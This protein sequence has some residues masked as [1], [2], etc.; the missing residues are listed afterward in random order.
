MQPA[1]SNRLH[2]SGAI[3]FNVEIDQRQLAIHKNRNPDN[4]LK[5]WHDADDDDMLSVCEGEPLYSCKKRRIDN[6]RTVNSMRRPSQ[7]ASSINGLAIKNED[8]DKASDHLSDNKHDHVNALR[9]LFFDC[10]QYNGISVSKWDF[11]RAGAQQAQFV[12]TLGGGNT[13]YCDEECHA[14]DT[15]CVDIPIDIEA[16]LKQK[17]PKIEELKP[18]EGGLVHCAAKK[19]TSKQKRTMTVRPLPSLPSGDDE[20]SQN[21]RHTR[22]R[23]IARGQ[24]IGTCMT[25]A[26]KGERVDISLSQNGIIG[27]QTSPLD[28]GQELMLAVF[29]DTPDKYKELKDIMD[30]YTAN[31]GN[32]RADNP[33]T[34]AYLHANMSKVQAYLDSIK[35]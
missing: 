31:G 12:T 4:Q 2:R 29:A 34:T 14:G 7:C 28:C 6:S 13:I 33:K 27:A 15:L 18:E 1:I 35:P 25:G 24:V 17:F 9:D 32:W 11:R 26:K 22:D 16:T 8:V 3:D 30:D 23:M 10:M 19:G 5:M 20:N 21:V